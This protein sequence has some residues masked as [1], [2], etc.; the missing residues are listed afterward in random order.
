MDCE[1]HVVPPVRFLEPYDSSQSAASLTLHEN[2]AVHVLMT[3]VHLA[4]RCQTAKKTD[5]PNLYRFWKSRW[6]NELRCTGFGWLRSPISINQES[7]DIIELLSLYHVPCVTL[8]TLSLSCQT[9][10]TKRQKKKKK[11]FCQMAVY[12]MHKAYP[13]D[14]IQ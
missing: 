1:D 4:H 2:D 7:E 6:N 9:T 3:H 14:L 10:L 13:G 12:H 5:H 11:N 8:C